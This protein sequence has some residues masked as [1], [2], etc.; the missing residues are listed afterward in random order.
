MSRNLIQETNPHTSAEREEMPTKVAFPGKVHI[1]DEPRK[2]SKL[3]LYRSIRACYLDIK[4]ITDKG[5]QHH[6]NH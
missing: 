4:S 5:K 2:P 1:T 3:E 6:Q